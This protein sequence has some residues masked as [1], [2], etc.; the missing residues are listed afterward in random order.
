MGVQ[1]DGLGARPDRRVGGRLG[2][3]GRGACGARTRTDAEAVPHARGRRDRLRGGAPCDHVLG[4]WRRGQGGPFAAEPR[5]LIRWRP[6]P[7]DVHLPPDRGGHAADFLAAVKDRG[8]TAVGIDIAVWSEVFVHLADVAVRTGRRITWDPAKEQ[9][10]GD[11]EAARLLY[12]TP[13]EPWGL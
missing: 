3:A 9:I 4:P 5:S 11:A 6:G 13:R 1:V 8:P 7:N 2:P 12:R 10:V